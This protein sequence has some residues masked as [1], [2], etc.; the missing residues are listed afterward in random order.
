MIN[1]TRYN[2]ANRKLTRRDRLRQNF[3]MDLPLQQ[4][5]SL[6]KWLVRNAI[7]VFFIAQF[8]CWGFFGYIPNLDMALLSGLSVVL[9]FGFG[10]IMAKKWSHVNEKRFLQK[11]FISGLVIRLLWMLYM[12]FIFNPYYFENRYGPSADVEWFMDFG[13][14]WAEWVLGNS[15]FT[16]TQMIDFYNSAVDDIGYPLWL[17]VI[18]ILTGGTSNV[19]IPMVIKCIISSYCAICIYRIARRHFGVATARIAA[20]FVCLNVNMIYWSASMMKEAEMVFI[21]CF[22]VD[23][24]DEILSSGNKLTLRAILP[25]VLLLVLL[26]FMRAVLGIVLCLAIVTHLI[27]ATNRVI[28]T[29]KK[30]LLGFLFALLIF[31]SLGERLFETSKEYLDLVQNDSQK[32]N[33]EWRSTREGGNSFAKY[34]SAS[35]F[36]PLIFTIPFPTFNVANESQILQLQLAGGYFIKNVLSVFVLWVM[37][38]L[39]ISGKWRQHVFILAY[40]CAYLIVLIFS[41]YAQSG[42]FHMPIWP[43]LMLFAAHGLQY[44]RQNRIL[45]KSYKY[46][47]LVEIVICLVWNWFKLKGRGM[48]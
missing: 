32:T 12:F 14:G 27:F 43:F 40:T 15:Q 24:L 3:A 11:V 23:M 37:F 31:T 39:L 41:G 38:V 1:K 16:L 46:A 33:M 5:V 34:A 20:L 21:C 29:N 19:F 22:V 10:Q 45:I 28:S 36:A 6:P 35:V 8:V 2:N 25:S 44:A 30:I 48:I 17:G 7:V 47:L 13:Q 42:R 26:F 4:R 9:F 18:Y